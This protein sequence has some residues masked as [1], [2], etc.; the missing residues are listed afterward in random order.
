MNLWLYNDSWD[1]FGK[2]PASVT[3]G[4]AAQR[5]SVSVGDKIV[6]A[7]N[8]IV[9]GIFEAQNHSQ[10]GF[11]I[12]LKPLLVPQTELVAKP[13]RYKISLEKPFGG[14]NCLYRLTEQEFGKIEL[15]IKEKKR[16]L[17]Y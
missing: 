4:S 8:G 13:L 3:F 2:N 1:E 6:Y 5:A 7:S 9:A 10:E 11:G 16:E 12:N 17:V 14:T 15:A